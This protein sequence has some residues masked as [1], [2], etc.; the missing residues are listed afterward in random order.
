M[1]INQVLTPCLCDGSNYFPA[2]AIDNLCFR[3]LQDKEATWIA[4]GLKAVCGHTSSLTCIEIKGQLDQVEP[5]ELLQNEEGLWLVFQFLG[6]SMVNNEHIHQLESATYQ[7]L[8]SQGSNVILQLDRGKTWLVLIGISGS[9][10]ADLK[11]EYGNIANL[12]DLDAKP[13]LT[14]K[15]I[16]YKYKRIFDKIQQAQGAAYSLPVTIAYHINQLFFLFDQELGA[17]EKNT[18]QQEVALYYRALAYI[19]EHFLEPKIPRKEIADQLCVHE[20]TLT[21]AFEQKKVTISEMIQ[22]VRLDKARDW[23]R[24]TD[25][26]I[27]EIAER[28]YF[29]DLALFEDAYHLLYKVYPKVDRDKSRGS[30]KSNAID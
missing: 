21:R 10:L 30:L 24:H 6:K 26:S 9:R 11:E 22:L 2:P 5:F 7:G 25:R 20:R 3:F 13:D 19:K 27:G 18:A 8:V 4:P 15:L 23:I 1:Y 16:G 28:L 17:L 29:E 12:F 14:P